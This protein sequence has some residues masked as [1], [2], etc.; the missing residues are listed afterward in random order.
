MDGSAGNESDSSVIGP[1]L[2]EGRSTR[3]CSR[4]RSTRVTLCSAGLAAPASKAGR[5]MF[6]SE[7]SVADTVGL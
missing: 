6:G 4:A 3:G 7:V 2:S 1:E 5:T